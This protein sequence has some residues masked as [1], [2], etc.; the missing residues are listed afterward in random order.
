MLEGGDA[1]VVMQIGSVDDDFLG[2]VVMCRA[3]GQVHLGGQDRAEIR[4]TV[5]MVEAWPMVDR[6]ID[7]RFV[8]CLLLKFRLPPSVRCRAFSFVSISAPDRGRSCFSFAACHAA[9]RSCGDLFASNP[10][11]LTPL[12]S[13]RSF[14]RSSD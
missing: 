12:S 13:Q 6:A 10:E 3:W 7:R 8:C 11:S 14:G 2:M 5:D 1:R 9:V 4:S